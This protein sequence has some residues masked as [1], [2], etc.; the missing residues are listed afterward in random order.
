[1]YKQNGSHDTGQ[2]PATESSIEMCSCSWRTSWA[3]S[4]L[5]CLLPGQMP[6]FRYIAAGDLTQQL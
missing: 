5:T 3:L 1:M 4:L 2:T 6:N